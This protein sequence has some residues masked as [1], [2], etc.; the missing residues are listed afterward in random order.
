MQ[1]L[2][3]WCIDILRLTSRD[4]ADIDFAIINHRTEH[5]ME[6]L[7]GAQCKEASMGG[8]MGREQRATDA[9]S[10]GEAE[11]M[12]YQVLPLVCACI[13]NGAVSRLAC[14]SLHAL[15]LLFHWNRWTAQGAPPS[16]LGA[17][18]DI[19]PLQHATFATYGIAT[20]T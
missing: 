5:M 13:M 14:R 7:L 20:C 8:N 18:Q 15:F 1:C 11:H 4:D 10:E 2:A 3:K 16:P 6:L 12:G 9:C 17:L 19:S